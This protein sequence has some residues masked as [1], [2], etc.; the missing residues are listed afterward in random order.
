MNK[1]ILLYLFIIF[2]LI[3]CSE[4]EIEWIN[5]SR[6]LSSYDS[7]RNLISIIEQD[8]KDEEWLN[9]E[10]IEYSYDKNG[11][12]TEKLTLF[13]FEGEWK[14]KQ[15][16]KTEFDSVNKISSK[17]ESG[18]RYDRWIEGSKD[19]YSY[20]NQLNRTEIISFRNMDNEWIESTKS[21][22]YY[23]D[24]GNEIESW[25]QSRKPFY[26]EKGGS[27]YTDEWL[28]PLNKHVNIVDGNGNIIEK[29]FQ[30]VE[31]EAWKIVEKTIYDYNPQNQI[32]TILFK[33]MERGNDSLFNVHKSKISYNNFG[34]EEEVLSTWENGDWK[35]SNQHTFLYDENG[36]LTEMAYNVWENNNWQNSFRTIYKYD[37]DSNEIERIVQE[38]K[39]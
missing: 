33:K 5:D 18:W 11:N 39:K 12:E 4:S 26:D 16:D 10:K 17:I 31:N 38:Y 1:V 23:N 14:N 15:L 29:Q 25:Y 24:F 19:I 37:K 13:W 32:V 8:W 2:P 21:Y 20:D 22:K 7:N 36:L 34:K 35:K 6:M 28:G 3:S 30:V 27:H 9:M